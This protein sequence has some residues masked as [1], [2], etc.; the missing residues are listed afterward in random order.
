MGFVV[1][2]SGPHAVGKTTVIK[3]LANLHPTWQAVDEIRIDLPTELRFGV[4]DT[5]LSLQGQ[6][7]WF[8]NE[9]QNM[10][11][12]VRLR[13]TTASPT[14]I[15]AE[16]DLFDVLA[17]SRVRLG[18]TDSTIMERGISALQRELLPLCNIKWYDFRIILHCSTEELV[19]RAEKR[20]PK[21]A[22]EWKEN[23]P[24]Y[25]EKIIDS[26]LD[27]AKGLVRCELVETTGQT[28]ESTAK[29]VEEIVLD[30][31]KK[32]VKAPESARDR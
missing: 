19:D 13:G 7:W 25:A 27:L 14:I 31:R 4:K 30:A 16:R 23:D 22:K 20:W 6:L 12:M 32:L 29:S 5:Y 11:E 1:I 3:W 9:I 10:C 26:Y 17:Y 15:L 2:I 28:V 8:C 24:D 21:R 18:P